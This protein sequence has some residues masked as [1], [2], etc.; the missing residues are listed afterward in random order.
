[1]LRGETIRVQADSRLAVMAAD[2]SSRRDVLQN[3]GGIWLEKINHGVLVSNAQ[4]QISHRFRERERRTKDRLYESKDSLEI[5][6]CSMS[7]RLLFV[8]VEVR[9]KYLRGQ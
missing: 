3:L 5:P 6:K 9:D 7:P 8:S 4:H 1:M 2:G